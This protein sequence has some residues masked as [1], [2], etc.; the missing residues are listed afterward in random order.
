MNKTVIKKTIPV[1]C[2][3]LGPLFHEYIHQKLKDSVGQCSQDHGYVISIGNF[4]IVD[5]EIS[6]A[7]T[8]TIA[9][10]MFEADVL[11]P[12]VGTQLRVTIASC[13]L[14]HGIYAYCQGKLKVL[15][16]QRTLKDY[17]FEN[18]SY[19]GVK[20]FM[21]GDEITITIT[22][23]KYDKNNFQCIGTIVE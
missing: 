17:K 1:E 21:V 4:K 19:V 6:R 22:A 23:I 13:V 16:P 14:S 12:E 10:V 3:A 8:E 5:T 9:T 15:V 20:N 7:T 18:G 2:Y 11:K